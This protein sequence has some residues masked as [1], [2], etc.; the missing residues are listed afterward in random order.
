MNSITLITQAQI[1]PHP[2]RCWLANDLFERTLNILNKGHIHV[3]AW[4][5]Q[6]YQ[7]LADIFPNKVK[8]LAIIAVL[9]FWQV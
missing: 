2:S 4:L 7:I 5:F 8:S 6:L 1:I 9:K 3:D